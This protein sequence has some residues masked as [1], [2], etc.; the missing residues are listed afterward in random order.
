MAKTSKSLFI[1]HFKTS[2]ITLIKLQ[3]FDNNQN[4]NLKKHQFK[5]KLER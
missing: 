4:K 3:N 1:I 2:L 5:K